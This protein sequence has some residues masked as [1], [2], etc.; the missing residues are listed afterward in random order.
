M[1]GLFPVAMEILE[2][3]SGRREGMDSEELRGDIFPQACSKW[4]LPFNFIMICN[5]AY[6]AVI[7]G[8]LIRTIMNLFDL[9]RISVMAFNA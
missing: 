9:K 8:S 4:N 6:C 5:Q 2:T 3:F 7:C 1:R